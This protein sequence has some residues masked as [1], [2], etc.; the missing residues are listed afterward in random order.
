MS[1]HHRCDVAALIAQRQE[2]VERAA[3]DTEQRPLR[4]ERE[5][6]TALMKRPAHVGHRAAPDMAPL[7]GVARRILGRPCADVELDEP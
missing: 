6:A 1:H 5:V 7:G 2:P 3:H 4:H